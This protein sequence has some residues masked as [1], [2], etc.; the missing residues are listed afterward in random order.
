MKGIRVNSISPSVINTNMHG[1]HLPYFLTELAR[2]STFPQRPIEHHEIAGSVLFLIENGMMN[3]QDVR[4][5]GGWRLVTDRH[6]DRP[7]HRSLAP[8]LE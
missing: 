4:I 3:G 1:S 7:D 2:S 5:D 6:P 8:G